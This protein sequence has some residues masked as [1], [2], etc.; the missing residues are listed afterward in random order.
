MFN[1][2]RRSN[3]T[4]KLALWYKQGYVTD[5]KAKEFTDQTYKTIQPLYK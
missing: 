2:L 1:D 3:A 4:L 5:N